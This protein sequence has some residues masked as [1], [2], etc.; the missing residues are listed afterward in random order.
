M[1]HLEKSQLQNMKQQQKL[2]FAIQWFVLIELIVYYLIFSTPTHISL[3]K[4][5]PLF[6][7]CGSRGKFHLSDST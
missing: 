5:L 7:R 4:C 3:A 6:T 2:C 1:I